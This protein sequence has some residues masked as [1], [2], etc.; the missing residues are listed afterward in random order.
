MKTDY[1][2]N[3]HLEGDAFF[4]EGGSVGVLLL[5]GLTATV[6]EVRP[7]AHILHQQGY[8]VAGPLLP[9]H[10]TTPAELNQVSW[11]DWLWTA[12]SSYHHLATVCDHVFV[13][14]EST[15]AVIALYLATKQSDVAGVLAYAP[16]IRLTLTTADILKLYAALPFK[17]MLEKE[18]PG[19]H[20]RWQGYGVYPL[21]ASRELLR[22]ADETEQRLDQISQPVL[23][24]Q[25]R[26]DG[27]IDPQSGQIIL[28]GVQSAY[29]ELHWME[30]SGHVVILDDELDEI[31]RI[32]HQFMQKA[33]QMSQ[34]PMTEVELKQRLQAAAQHDYAAPDNLFELALAMMHH[35]GSTDEELRD[36]LISP[37]FYYW[38]LDRLL[39]SD[40]QMRQ[41]LQLALDEEHLFY[42]LG[43]K[44]TDSVFT[45]TFSMLLLPLLLIVH[46]DKRPYLTPAEV[47]NVKN[48]L[49][50]YL[51]TEQ[52][53]RGYVAGP[54]W[55][56]AMA[57]AA[58]ALDD[59]V[60]C[61]ELGADDLGELLPVMQAAMCRHE[62]PFSHEEDER[63]V[64]AVLATYKRQLIPDA[65][66][67]TW[68]KR[69]TQQAQQHEQSPHNYQKLNAKNFLRS[70]YFRLHQQNLGESLRAAI[71]ETLYELSNFK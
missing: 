70:L 53:M 67:Q 71:A 34:Q 7:L 20:P 41:L 62:R 18:N 14:G 65:A 21:W 56:H 63:M 44:D 68:I 61:T 55:A 51:P 4:W 52:D 10:G 50:R 29:T 64:T 60:Q 37:A 23:I 69:F 8:T 28:D 38:V 47:L 46:R 22:L 27:T 19:D 3:P 49:L 59:I 42:K 30:Q 57:H 48:A 26:N 43:E 1:L 6:A 17:D 15:G 66:W 25:G 13:G 36:G 45:R 35:I 11:R 16:A 58:D 40:E 33:I 39:F 32:T 12:E 9:G 5:H 2:V 31:A 24:V 54:G